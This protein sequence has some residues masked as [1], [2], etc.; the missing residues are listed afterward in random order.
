MPW[1]LEVAEYI[2]VRDPRGEEELIALRALDPRRTYLAQG[3]Y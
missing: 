1:D 2:E 3:C